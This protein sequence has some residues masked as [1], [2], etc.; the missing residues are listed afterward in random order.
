MFSRF[1]R[2]G[3]LNPRTGRAYR[4]DI[5]APSGTED[6]DVLVQR[7]LGRPVS[8]AA[9]YRELGIKAPR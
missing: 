6:P 5:L 1:E 4:D 8:Y 2:E 7:F 9:F 3:V